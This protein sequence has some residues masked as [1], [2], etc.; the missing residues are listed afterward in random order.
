MKEKRNT[1]ITYSAGFKGPN[2]WYSQELGGA[3]L[4]LEEGKDFSEKETYGIDFIV[5]KRLAKEIGYPPK[6]ADQQTREN[7]TKRFNEESS[8]KAFAIFISKQI[9]KYKNS[10]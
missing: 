9:L 3:T 6:D 2:R 4:I 8:K 5:S 1:E 10:K 7:Y